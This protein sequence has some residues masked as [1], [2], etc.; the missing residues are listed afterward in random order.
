MGWRGD[1]V[2]YIAM[3]PQPPVCVIYVVGWCADRSGL[4]AL[5]NQHPP[6][7][8]IGGIRE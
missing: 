2:G 1:S 4:L 7:V 6:V 8:G 3:G 5:D